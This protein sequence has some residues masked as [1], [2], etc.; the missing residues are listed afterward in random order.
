M[1]RWMHDSFDIICFGRSYW[2]LHK[3][4]DEKAKELS[5]YHRIYNHNWYWKFK[6][7]WDF[8]NPFPI[9]ELDKT[10]SE[11]LQSIPQG[12]KDTFERLAL[13]EGNFL[14]QEQLVKEAF[15]VYV[16]HCF[17]DRMWDEYSTE[18]RQWLKGF[19]MAWI[20]NPK[21]L[22]EKAGVDV[23]EG[24][25]KVKRNGEEWEDSSHLK[26]DYENLAE[27]IRV[28]LDEMTTTNKV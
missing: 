9:R 5:I 3:K 22:Y 20:L 10:I 19:V 15:Q 12:L 28:E 4:I 13:T 23:I 6:Q 7:K 26:Q 27:I 8:E 14:S 11:I 25:V 2:W 1:K 21:L 16:C 18:E 24:K 17:W